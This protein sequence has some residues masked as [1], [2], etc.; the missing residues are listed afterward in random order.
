MR[1]LYCHGRADVEM[2]LLTLFAVPR[3][4]CG[5]CEI[6]I[7]EWRRG[8]RCGR[9]HRLM[10]DREAECRDCLFISSRF[11]PVG[12]I[13]CMLD[14]NEEVKMLMHR[15]K[16]VR[17][18]A[19]AEVLSYF[20]TFRQTEYDHVVPIPVSEQRFQR[21]GFNQVTEVLDRAGVV[22]SD[23]LETEKIKHQS[24]L[25]KLERMNSSN[26]FTFNRAYEDVRLQGTRIL[27]VDDIYTTGITVHHAAEVLLHH[28]TEVVDVLT[29]SKA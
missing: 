7:R 1:C 19:L 11:R 4:L 12:K 9:C 15:Y 18:V 17:D 2:N 26:P 22:H 5:E 24:E 29:F 21:R 16:F 13:M 20:I 10:D 28:E 3:S 6:K 27:V 8:K 14:Y 25:S 23:M